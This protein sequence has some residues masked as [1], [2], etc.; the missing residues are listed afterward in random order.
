MTKDKENREK[1]MAFKADILKWKNE[2]REEYN[3]FAR[4]MT[5]CDETFYYQIFKAVSGQMRHIAREWE[6]TWGD[7]GDESFDSIFILVSK[8]NLPQKID[9]MFSVPVPDT[10]RKHRWMNIVKHIIGMKPKMKVRL[11]APLLLSWL[12]YGKSFESMVAMLEKQ[13]SNPHIERI[14][15]MKCSL[16]YKSIIAVSVKGGYRTK[17]DWESYFAMEKADKDNETWE[18]ALQDVMQDMTTEIEEASETEDVQHTMPGRKKSKGNPLI[19]YLPTDSGEAIVSYIRSFVISHQSAMQ[20]ALPYFVLRE[21]PLRLPLLNGVE[22]AI[23]M[24][25]QFPEVCELRSDHSLRQAVGKL[26]GTDTQML[27]KDGKIQVCRYIESDEYRE[28][29]RQ[30][31]DDLREWFHKT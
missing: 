6:L 7:D 22:Y 3:E 11:S 8:E 1:F 5:N 21:M 4:I 25:K 18:W 10:E 20:Q 30:L 19:D 17:E 31:R 28:L 23:A 13:M 27:M 9:E 2:H 14:D 24:T 16:A 26:A 15:R 12:F 29:L